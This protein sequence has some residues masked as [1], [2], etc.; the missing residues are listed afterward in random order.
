LRKLM[1]LHFFTLDFTKRLREREDPLTWTIPLLIGWLTIVALA[2]A[3]AYSFN[4]S[5]VF[6]QFSV[7]ADTLYPA[8]LTEELRADLGAALRFTPSR[9]PSFLPDLLVAVS[10]DALTGNWRLAFW[11]LGAVN[12]T[13]LAVVG[14]WIASLISGRWVG[15][16]ALAL[17]LPMALLL[18]AGL[19]FH[20]WASGAQPME[21]FDQNLLVN[22]QILL[23]LPIW[24]GG[25]FV[26]G[27]G[28][29]ALAWCCA[30]NGGRVWGLIALLM[31]SAGAAASNTITIAHAVLPAMIALAD[32][33]W[34]GAFLRRAA[35]LAAA[36]AM[37]LGAMFG[38]WLA[39]ASKREQLPLRPS[40]EWIEA[41]L[42]AILAL[43]NQPVIL[44]LLVA[45]LPIALA[46]F[47]PRRVGAL[48]PPGAH[49]MALRYFVV[50]AAAACS[51]SVLITMGLYA[52]PMSWR[53]A[54]P[55]AWWPLILG[56][57][58]LA[59][60]AWLWPAWLLVFGVVGAQGGTSP[61][62]MRW[63]HPVTAC[64]DAAD[65]GIEWR[66]GLSHYWHARTIAATGGWRRQVES[67]DL[68][69]STLFAWISDPRSHFQA[70]HG[71]PGTLPSYRF[72]YM[73]FM[74]PETITA[75][76]GPPERIVPCGGTPIWVSPP[77]WQPINWLIALADPLVPEALAIGR[78]VCIA[79]ER[80]N[81]EGLVLNVPAGA[82]RLALTGA[83][84]LRLSD[85]RSGELLGEV[86]P[87]AEIHLSRATPL[88]ISPVD[89]APLRSLIIGPALAAAVAQG[90]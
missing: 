39:S 90:C 13:L 69:D 73:L 57:A 81:A 56:M 76:H 61:A 41:G 26:I 77:D 74:D 22:P 44:A 19:G 40:H 2:L 7:Q 88:R 9:T 71:A 62:I 87:L 42:S 37:A 65:P 28:V 30:S 55:L 31:L 14:G 27:L 63:Q 24:H 47:R 21:V 64:L 78:E 10:I 1:R 3:V 82:F 33:V 48:L 5:P 70:R 85:A 16:C 29:L 17:A 18:L 32:G 15:A 25:G 80:V 79:P 23:M 12:F 89:A 52:E 60:R 43:P 86:A 54:V 75:A 58:F 35:A 68:R 50:A 84:R 36:A 67:M 45:A 4:N 38:F 49:H 59:E 11:L 66:A 34:R 51:A 46:F 83:A 20:L 53:Y 6:L 72:I 8:L